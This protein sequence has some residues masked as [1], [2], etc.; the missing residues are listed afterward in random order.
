MRL[1]RSLPATKESVGGYMGVTTHKYISI[2]QRG[3]PFEPFS[4][5]PLWIVGGNV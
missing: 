2:L 5:T 4:I 3:L 1:K